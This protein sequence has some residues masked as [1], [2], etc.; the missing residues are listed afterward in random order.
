[1]SCCGLP[2]A[3]ACLRFYFAS[4]AVSCILSPRRVFYCG[5]NRCCPLLLTAKLQQHCIPSPPPP[6]FLFRLGLDVTPLRRRASDPGS[7]RRVAVRCVSGNCYYNIL[8]CPA[9]VASFASNSVFAAVARVAF[10]NNIKLV[11]ATFP[12]PPPLHR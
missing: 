7:K 5:L 6:C 10:D 3:L 12:L 4:A 2:M 8:P 9:S 1:M 11:C